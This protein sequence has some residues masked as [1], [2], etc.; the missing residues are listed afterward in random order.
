MDLLQRKSIIV[1]TAISCCLSYCNTSN[2]ESMQPIDGYQMLRSK[3]EILQALKDKCVDTIKIKKGEIIADIGAGNGELEAMLSMFYDSL[4]FFIQDIDSMVCNQKAIDKVVADYQ[5]VNNKPF[6]NKFIAVNGSDIETNLPDDTF[7][8]I[9]MLWTY[10]YLKKPRD[11]LMDIRQKLKQEGLFYV[12]NPDVDEKDGKMLTLK[13][14]WNASPIEKEI[15][16]IIGCGF[17]LIRISRNNDGPD[18]PYIMVFKK[19]N[20][21]KFCV[22]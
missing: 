22:P 17:E 4:T 3:E 6:T 16:D 9:L 18:Q 11:L 13:H 20:L 15:S 7:D 10:Q 19:K 5:G 1:I 21:I 14:G 12:I 8:K 2:K